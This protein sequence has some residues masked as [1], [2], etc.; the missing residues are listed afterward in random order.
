MTNFYIHSTEGIGWLNWIESDPAKKGVDRVSN[1]TNDR[2]EG[3]NS[4]NPAMEWNK[5]LDA[6]AS[7]PQEDIGPRWKDP[8]QRQVCES[9]N[10][11]PMWDY[12]GKLSGNSA[13]TVGQEDI[14]SSAKSVEC[15]LSIR[16]ISRIMQLEFTELYSNS[17][18]IYEDRMAT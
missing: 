7:H 11:G 1:G 12:S 6:P 9:N 13:E 17:S 4:R 5:G 2:L 14:G 15:L 18:M 3:G 8:Q 16:C 10:T